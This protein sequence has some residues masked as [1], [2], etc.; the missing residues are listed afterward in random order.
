[1][2]GN[3]EVQIGLFQKFLFV[4]TNHSKY[5]NL[6]MIISF[7]RVNLSS[8]HNLSGGCPHIALQLV[9]S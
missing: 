7:M 9:N 5:K 8:T 1:M 2:N 4:Q 6:E 3:E